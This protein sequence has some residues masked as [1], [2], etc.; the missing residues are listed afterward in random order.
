MSK[1][2]RG[3]VVQ[4][5]LA[6]LEREPRVDLHHYPIAIQEQEDRLILEGIV[7]NIAAKKL[8]LRIA[9]RVCGSCP[10]LDRL[11][12]AA[13]HMEEGQLRAEV[14]NILMGE[15]V[16][17][18][19]GIRLKRDASVETWRVAKSTTDEVIEVEVRDGTV[20]LSGRVGSL[21]HRRLAEVLVW[22]TA[23]C[24]LVENRLRVVPPEKEND[25]ELSDAVRIVLEKDP[26][27]HSG[28]I[29]IAVE[30]GEVT[31]NGYV[32]SDEER[33][34]AVLDAWY[35][36]GVREVVDHIQSRI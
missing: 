4:D 12:V 33:R 2:S 11:H 32:A 26:L 19:Y 23:G 18:E 34:L 27:V 16:F 5:L 14:I 29:S 7:A 28:Q 13:S 36:P 8:A 21:T 25:G 10:V 30:H 31:L 15:P 20:V 22:W 9:Q 17:A 3:G 24:E 6:A 1:S 35:V